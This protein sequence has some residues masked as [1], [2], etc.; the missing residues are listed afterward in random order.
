MVHTIKKILLA[1]AVLLLLAGCGARHVPTETEL[2]NPNRTVP[3]GLW[4]KDMTPERVEYERRWEYTAM[5]ETD[6]PVVIGALIDAVKALEIGEEDGSVTEDY[7]DILT[8]HF[9]D[10]ETLRLEFENQ[11]LVTEDGTRY[12]VDGLGELRSLLNGIA[13]EGS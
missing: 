8:F 11:N 3:S 4:T 5:Y 9:S 1:C 7:T 2:T 10:G 6:N 13:E 12:Q